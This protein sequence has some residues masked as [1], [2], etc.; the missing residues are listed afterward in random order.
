[1]CKKAGIRL[2]KFQSNSREVLEQLDPADRAE[3]MK[4]VDLSC[5]NLPVGR[6]L[7][8]LWNID[9]DYFSFAV[10]LQDRPLTRRGLLSTVSSVYDPFGFL[11]P[12]TLLGKQMLQQ[13]CADQIDWDD[14]IPEGLKSKWTQWYPKVC[15]ANRFWQH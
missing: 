9:S 4:N 3:D 13:M 15:E 1:M 7:G 12:A 10:K 6:A 14:P 8:V 2:H 11:S 5:E